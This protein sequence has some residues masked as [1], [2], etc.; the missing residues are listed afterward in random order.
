MQYVPPVIEPTDTGDFR[1]KVIFRAVFHRV[2]RQR[3][4]ID[5]WIEDAAGRAVDG[6]I[7]ARGGVDLV[8]TLPVDELHARHAVDLSALDEVLEA[9]PIL[10]SKADDQF[11]GALER[12]IQFPGHPVKLRVAFHRALRFQGAG[13]VQEA[14]VQHAGVPAA[15]LGADVAL[16][17]KHCDIQLKAGQLARH[18]AADRAA[19]DDDHIVILHETVSSLCSEGGCNVC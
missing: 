17:L 8:H 3:D 7:A 11:S 9:L 4:G 12:H 6:E 10:V 1:I 15:G 13:F 16:L 18:R 19:A 5:K 14:R 2:F